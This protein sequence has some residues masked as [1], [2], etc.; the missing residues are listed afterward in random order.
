[1]DAT[2]IYLGSQL[3]TFSDGE[4]QLVIQEVQPQVLDVGAQAEAARQVLSQPLTLL[5]PNAT[6]GDAGPYVYNPQIL[7]NLLSVQRGQNGVQV[8]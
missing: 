5:I 7:A 8:V 1:M 4:V 3:Q 6:T 2:L